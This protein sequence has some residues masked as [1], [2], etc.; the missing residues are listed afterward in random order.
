MSTNNLKKGLKNAAIGV[1]IFLSFYFLF[2]FFLKSEYPLAEH[3]FNG[4]DAYDT[5]KD[6]I[7]LL[8][9]FVIA[10]IIYHI[11]HAQKGKEVIAF[12]AREIIKNFLEYIVALGKLSH[13]PPKIHEELVSEVEN[14]KRLKSQVIRGLHYFT[15]CMED[16]KLEKYV[17]EYV[18]KE[19]LLEQEMNFMSRKLGPIQFKKDIQ[20]AEHQIEEVLNSAEKV[21]S[22]IKPYSTYQ[23]RFKFK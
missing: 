15:E 21:I 13:L 11:W 20:A 9:P 17:D 8:S 4:K 12:E 18:D 14:L 1:V 6:A 10:Y 2:A 23:K 19:A 3:S 5:F 16:K 22:E 7:T